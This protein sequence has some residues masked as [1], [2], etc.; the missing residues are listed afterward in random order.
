M[1]RNTNDSKWTEFT[2]SSWP[3]NNAFIRILVISQ[4][5]K[6]K[7][8]PG[9]CL[10]TE[11]GETY[12]LLYVFM[13]TRIHISP[14]LRSIF[15]VLDKTEFYC[16]HTKHAGSKWHK[17]FPMNFFFSYLDMCEKKVKYIFTDLPTLI[18]EW[19]GK[20]FNFM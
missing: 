2:L 16:V 20:H 17:I 19:M 14:A 4:C 18:F 9:I 10:S 7:H 12:V 13:G 6:F 5:N 11:N 3:A 1:Y 15:Y 8:L